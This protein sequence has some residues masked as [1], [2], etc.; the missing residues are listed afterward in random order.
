MGKSVYKDSYQ[1]TKAPPA[2]STKGMNN[3]LKSPLSPPDMKF[4]A[5]SITKSSY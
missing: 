3:P 2:V 1:G 4:D 5:V